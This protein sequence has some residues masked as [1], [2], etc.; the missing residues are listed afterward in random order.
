[1]KYTILNQNMKLDYPVMQL[2][3]TCYSSAQGVSKLKRF[4]SERNINVENIAP[5]SYSSS[6]SGGDIVSLS[7]QSSE[8]DTVVSSY[9]EFEVN[10]RLVSGVE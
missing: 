3:L 4:Q 2:S 5:P 9:E 10:P 7:S 1:M 6:G 8:I